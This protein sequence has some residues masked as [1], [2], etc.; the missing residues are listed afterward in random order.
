MILWSKATSPV[1]LSSRKVVEREGK[2]LEG[3]GKGKDEGNIE[4][5]VKCSGKYVICKGER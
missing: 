1:L 5:W 2:I 4:K 3:L